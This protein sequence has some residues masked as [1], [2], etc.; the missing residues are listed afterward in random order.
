MTSILLTLFVAGQV[1]TFIV[2]N[3]CPPKFTVVNAVPKV[4]AVPAVAAKPTF[5]QPQYHAGHDCPSCGRPQ[6]LV[7]SGI[8]N[9]AGHT[10]RCSSC[11]TVWRH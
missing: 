3:R 5:R 6:W 9:V 11:G 8:A 1:P 7:H 10:H 2:E 4:K